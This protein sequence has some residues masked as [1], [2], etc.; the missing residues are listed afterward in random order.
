[1]A[2][3][4]APKSTS[5]R[6]RNQYEI[7]KGLREHQENVDLNN[8]ILAEL[9]DVMDDNNSNGAQSRRTKR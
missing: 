3:H 2:Q 6:N 1:M 5:R 9:N 7:E 4:K 8:E